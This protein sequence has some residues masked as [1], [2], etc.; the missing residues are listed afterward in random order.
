MQKCPDDGESVVCAV[1]DYLSL[2]L[3]LSL[4]LLFLTFA[5]AVISAKI[6]TQR[7]ESRRKETLGKLRSL[8]D[9]SWIA[10][11]PS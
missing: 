6:L 4:S 5:M 7:A 3:S 11:F 2:S 10:N 9:A 8:A 1:D